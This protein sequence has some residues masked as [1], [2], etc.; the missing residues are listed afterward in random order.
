M[1]GMVS[2]A[3]LNPDLPGPVCLSVWKFSPSLGG[4]EG[5]KSRDG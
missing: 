4:E 1:W 2:L 3:R 5:L